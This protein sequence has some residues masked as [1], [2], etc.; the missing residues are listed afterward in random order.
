MHVDCSGTMNVDDLILCQFYWPIKC[1]KHIRKDWLMRDSGKWYINWINM[2]HAFKLVKFLTCKHCSVRWSPGYMQQALTSFVLESDV[3]I[4][5]H[6]VATVLHLFFFFCR[7]A[8]IADFFCISRPAV[9]DRQEDWSGSGRPRDDRE[10]R[11]LC[12][13]LQHLACRWWKHKPKQESGLSWSA[14]LSA[15]SLLTVLIQE[16]MCFGT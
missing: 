4:A 7:F 16:G 6:I 13:G 15:T 12:S 5:S 2:H 1:S 14:V 8:E 9:C 11:P 3:C 10:M